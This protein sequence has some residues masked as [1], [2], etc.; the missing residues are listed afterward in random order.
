[1]QLQELYHFY[2]L[3]TRCSG[4]LIGIA[5][6]DEKTTKVT[7]KT[8]QHLTHQDIQKQ[9]ARLHNEINTNVIMLEP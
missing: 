6:V 7:T 8:D 2:F 9:R 1:M 3:S 4:S 5:L